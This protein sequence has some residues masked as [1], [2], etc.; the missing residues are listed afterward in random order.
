MKKITPLIFLILMF[1]SPP[2]I[3]SHHMGAAARM[4]VRDGRGN[5]RKD[6]TLIDSLC[7]A[8]A[9]PTKSLPASLYT[10]AQDGRGAGVRPLAA[11]Q[12]VALVIGNADY[13][14]DIGRLKNPT[15]D[16]TDVAS[17]LRRLD[18]TLVGGKA[19]LNLNKRQMLELIREFGSRIQKGGVG[20]FYFAGHGVQ[21]DK[22]NYLIP[23]TDLLQYQ[24]DAAYEAVDADAVLREMDY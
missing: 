6:E 24:E 11:N 14:N 12:R 18:F 4:R 7:P 23:I 22:H 10:W 20:V 9:C 2:P 16:A 3:A 5:T 21:V 19:H 1:G 8:A 15:N 17:A 13:N